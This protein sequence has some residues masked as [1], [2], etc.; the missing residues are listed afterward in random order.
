MTPE[1]ITMVRES[2]DRAAGDARQLVA[3]FYQRLFELDP[4]VRPLFATEPA[5]LEAKFFAELHAIVDA[6]PSFDDFVGRTQELGR[7]HAGYGVRVNHYAEARD[8]LLWALG[9]TLGDS[10][11]PEVHDAWR[12]AYNLVAE[13]MMASGAPSAAANSS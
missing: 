1:Q 9:A 7:R 8:A 5:V 6:L 11:T 2:L 3:R 4:D 13:V 10:F 12:M